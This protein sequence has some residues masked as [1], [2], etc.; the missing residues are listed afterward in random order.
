ML[1]IKLKCLK[2]IKGVHTLLWSVPGVQGAEGVCVPVALMTIR[3]RQAAQH[4]SALEVSVGT[5]KQPNITHFGTGGFSRDSQAGLAG[6][7][8]PR[9]TLAWL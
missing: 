2:N 6:E 3:E 4:D 7:Y 1:I 8:S 9:A 5:A